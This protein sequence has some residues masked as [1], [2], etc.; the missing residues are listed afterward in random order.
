MQPLIV[1]PARMASSRL[2][3]KPLADIGGKPMIVRVCERA[4]EADIG[5]VLV[6]AAEAEIADAVRKESF[7]AVLTDPE[8][9]S[10]SDRVHAAAGAY[11]SAGVYD[12]I[13]NFQGD[14]PTLPAA[15]LKAAL[16]P[17]TADPLCDL[18]TLVCEIT[19]PGERTDPNVV[20]VVMTGRSG[21]DIRR[22]LYF[23]RAEAPA[24]DGPLWHHVGVYAWRRAALRDFVRASP[25]EL[26]QRERLEQLRALELGMRIDCAVISGPP[27]NGVDTPE[28]LAAARVIL[29]GER[30]VE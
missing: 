17:L 25:T 15:A 18:A 1:I 6:A 8:L 12:I 19:D 29:A 30:D 7:E 10:G 28:D 26:E 9:P 5:P 11:D 16:R 20:K 22:A 21:D 14:M 24:G 4:R 27:P 23:T 3:G 2:P 13:I